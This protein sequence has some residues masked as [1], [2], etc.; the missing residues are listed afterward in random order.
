LWESPPT[1]DANAAVVFKGPLAEVSLDWS[2]D[3]RFLLYRSQTGPTPQVDLLALPLD[4]DRKP[5]PVA[6]TAA[7][8][9][10]G[11][12]S[13]DGK[14]LAIESD[15]T[16]TAEIYLQQFPDPSVKVTA[17]TGGGLSPTWGPDGKEIF[18]I[19]PHGQLMV[20]S[21]DFDS[22]GGV[23]PAAPRELFQTRVGSGGSST[24]EYVISRDGR[25]FLLNTLVEQTGSP[26]NLIFRRS[27]ISSPEGASR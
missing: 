12:F 22:G 6:T 17:S 4:G 14:W 18:Y 24:R 23:R 19:T 13:P 16:G 10:A 21:L 3:G 11:A 25:R 15:L 27:P 1:S 20:V 2:R 8:E 26:I 5:I 7:D 9:T